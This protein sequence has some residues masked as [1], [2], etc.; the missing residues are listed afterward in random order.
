M[1]AGFAYARPVFHV[2]KRG[3]SQIKDSFETQDH[4]RRG[5]DCFS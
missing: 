5:A 3:G 4:E 2:N 1:S